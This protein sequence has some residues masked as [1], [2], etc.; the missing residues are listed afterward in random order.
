M[1]DWCMVA[2]TIA[3]YATAS[4]YA[5]NYDLPHLL[6]GVVIGIPIGALAM[7]LGMSARQH[8][9]DTKREMQE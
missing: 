4:W 6:S 1:L 7:G 2:L 8:K 9:E 5:Y 3:L